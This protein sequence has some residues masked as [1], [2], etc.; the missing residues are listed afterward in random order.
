MDSDEEAEMAGLRSSARHHGLSRPPP[1]AAPVE[2]STATR[3]VAKTDDGAA[4]SDDDLAEDSAEDLGA[5]RTFL[6]QSFGRQEAPPGPSLEALHLS[7]R[8]KERREEIADR[9]SDKKTGVQFGPRTT[10]AVMAAGARQ[11]AV[12]GASTM[13]HKAG[14]KLQEEVGLVEDSRRPGPVGQDSDIDEEGDAAALDDDDGIPVSHEV[15]IAA[16]EKAVTA[17][18]LDPRGSR[19]VTGS[20]DGCMKFYDFAGMNEEKQAFR[21]LEPV[22]GHMVQAVSFSTTGGLLLAVCSDSHARVYDRD[23]SSKPVQSTVKGDMYVRDMTHTKGHTQM[24]T[25]GVWHPLHQEQWVTSSLDGTLRLWDL[26]ATPVGMDQV[27]PSVHV[28]K[29]LDKRNVCIGGGSGR[30]GGLHPTCCVLSPTDG[31][32][33]VGGCSDGSLQLFF[34]KARYQKPDKILRTAHAAPVSDATFIREG[35][36]TNLLASRSLDNTMK[37][38]DLRMFSDQRGPVK[39]FDGLPHEHEKIGLCASPDGKHLVTA[40]APKRGAMG[41]ASILIYD[42]KNFSLKR[43][44]RLEKKAAVRFLWPQE[45]NQLV[46]STSSGDV[47]M[48]YN[49]SISVK[50]ALHFV[51][52]RTK[53]KPLSMVEDTGMGPIFNMTDRDDI[54]KFFDTGSGNMQRIRRIEARQAQKTIKPYQPPTHE[55]GSATAR[56]AENLAFAAAVHK[57]GAQQLGLASASQKEPDSQK[58]LLSYASKA[59]G[60]QSL[61]GRAYQTTQPEKLLDWSVDKSE[62]DKRMEEAMKG[63]FCR[64][65]GQKVCRCVDYS[66]WSRGREAVNKKP[67]IA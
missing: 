60:D 36:Q 38:W 66:T 49:P 61:F 43:N 33:I 59:D 30:T 27:L 62:G 51:G 7:T 53:S 42:A 34:E 32:K 48:L 28:L 47:V 39:C 12:R 55:A 14:G 11:R 64:K 63:D 13:Q 54:K 16:H 41:D 4:S 2:S 56:G 23:G 40:I 65:C 10:D 20:M 58:A 67:R 3:S 15:S 5:M 19:M 6:P 46:V 26:N 31:K 44:I 9:V 37:V 45:L 35:N 8:R 57:S 18:S 22:D 17:L 25:S 24:L 21:W 52:K 50:G 29:T 1:G